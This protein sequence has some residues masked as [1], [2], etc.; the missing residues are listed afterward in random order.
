[1]HAAS[2][3]T[4]RP[5][6][7]V[8]DDTLPVRLLV[9]RALT[10]A[11]YHVLTAPDGQS[12]ITLIEGHRAPPDLVVTDLRMPVMRG[13]H[14][15]Q[16]LRQRYPH[17]PIVFMSGFGP[18]DDDELAGPFLPKPFTP[19]VLCALVRETLAGRPGLIANSR[20]ARHPIAAIS[21]A[22]DVARR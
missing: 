17:L 2:T 3:A 9:S 5:V 14:L 18:E 15:A 22:A 13:E 12:A 21:P 10:D 8:V 7:L 4:D 20:P 19:D 11:G 1:M 16:W 6:V